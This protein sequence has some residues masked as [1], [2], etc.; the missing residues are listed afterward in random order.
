[1]NK[2]M[3]IDAQKEYF[4]ERAHRANRAEALRIL[5]RAGKGNPPIEGDELPP[6][7]EMKK[8]VKRTRSKKTSR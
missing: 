2:L 1:M 3:D 6:D 4:R 5:K 7:W 8:P